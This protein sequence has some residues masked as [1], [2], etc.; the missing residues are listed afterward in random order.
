MPLSLSTRKVEIEIERQKKPRGCKIGKNGKAEIAE[1]VKM[2]KAEIAEV[3]AEKMVRGL[4]VLLERK[5][6]HPPPGP[7][8][9]KYFPKYVW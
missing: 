4:V 5:I 9:P 7:P 6:A 8:H 1:V 2:R 3:E